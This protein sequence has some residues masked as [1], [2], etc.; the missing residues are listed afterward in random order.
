LAETAVRNPEL[1]EEK[2]PTPQK[3][4]DTCPTCSPD[5]KYAIY[6]RVSEYDEAG[7][8]AP[9]WQ[10]NNCGR[11]VPIKTRTGFVPGRMTAA[12]VRTIDRLKVRLPLHNGEFADK[13]EWKKFE[14]SMTDYGVVWLTAEHGRIGDEDTMAAVLCRDY[15]HIAIGPRGGLKFATKPKWQI[16]NRRV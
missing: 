9:H 7:K 16:E 11:L 3:K 15:W 1:G 14:T 10:C 4:H 2:M 13:Y 8:F 5:E 6:T 12:Q